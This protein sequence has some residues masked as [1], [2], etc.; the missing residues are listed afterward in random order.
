MSR[1]IR[2]ASKNKLI[3]GRFAGDFTRTLQTFRW[4]A[5]NPKMSPSLGFR[6][7]GASFLIDL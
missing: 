5:L 7:R 6:Q 3:C 1:E 4:A 2:H